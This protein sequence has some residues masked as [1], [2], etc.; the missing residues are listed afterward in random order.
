MRQLIFQAGISCDKK[1]Q[2][3]VCF[4]ELNGGHELCTAPS[5][6]RIS[7]QV[8]HFAVR[9]VRQPELQPLPLSP[10]RHHPPMSED[11][12]T[13]PTPTQRASLLP[14]DSP[15]LVSGFGLSLRW[16]IA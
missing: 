10:R 5:V 4:A 2:Q 15:T 6:A 1:S 16:S 8:W 12:L 11:P 14:A 3:P 9:A 13:R 7:R